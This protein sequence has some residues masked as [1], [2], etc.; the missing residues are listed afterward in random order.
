M[1]A[2]EFITRFDSHKGFTEKELYDFTRGFIQNIDNVWE[3]EGGDHR[4]QR[5][6]TT[7]IQIG[8]RY[9]SLDWM[10]GLTEYQED[11]FYDQPYEVKPVEK[12][13]VVTEWVAVEQ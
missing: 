11:S 13:I 12:T 2:N 8:D 4:W 10:K 1:N 5:E 3:E 6:M 7:I 9:F